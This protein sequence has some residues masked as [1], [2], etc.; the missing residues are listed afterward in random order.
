V[1]LVSS[2][3]PKQRLRKRDKD[4]AK[5]ILSLLQDQ[6]GTVGKCFGCQRVLEIQLLQLHHKDGVINH[7]E[8]G[9]LELADQHCNNL[10]HAERS[11]RVSDPSHRSTVRENMGAGAQDGTPWS[12]REGVKHERMRARFNSLLADTFGNQIDAELSV[13]YLARVMVSRVGEGSSVTFRRY[14]EE[15]GVEGPLLTY[16]REDGVRVA[17]YVGRKLSPGERFEALERP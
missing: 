11:K 6:D 17:R 12:S 3:K 10:E 5:M 2:Y 16:T 7:N 1:Q 14:I 8:L 4:L 13:D 9:N 15:D